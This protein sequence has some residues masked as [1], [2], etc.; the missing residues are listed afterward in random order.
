[1]SR[2]LAP[3]YLSAGDNDEIRNFKS[4][5]SA[6]LIASDPKPDIANRSS[7][8]AATDQINSYVLNYT[9]SHGLSYAVIRPLS[10][11]ADLDWSGTGYGVSTQCAAVPRSD[12]QILVDPGTSYFNCTTQTPRGNILG[13]LTSLPHKTWT[14]DWHAYLT[15]NR[16]LT[17]AP[18]TLVSKDGYNVSSSRN[19]ISQDPNTTFRNPWHWMAKINVLVEDPELPESFLT[20]PHLL[21]KR[22]DGNKS[23]FLLNCNT[24]GEC[25]FAVRIPTVRADFVVYD[26][27]HTVVNNMITSLST[28]KSNGSVAGMVS[29]TSLASL[30]FRTLGNNFVVFEVNRNL[31]TP[32]AFIETYA[33]SMSKRM[34]VPLVVHTVPA[35]AILVQRRVTSVVTKLPKLALWLLVVANLFFA[36]LGLVLAILAL[37]VTSPK[38]HQ[39]Q[40]RLSTAGLVA[41]LFDPGHAQSEAKND[42]KLFERDIRGKTVVNEVVVGVQCTASGGAEFVTEE[43]FGKEVLGHDEETLALQDEDTV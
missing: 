22:N 38:V 8:V 40:I 20:S 21:K 39:V 36:L 10:I 15:E 26:T 18:T 11:D 35:P 9:D 34:S 43:F 1:M 13:G 17:D 24:T 14:D 4:F 37:K 6:A 42:E 7:Y 16:S 31:T 27:E 12:C 19:W 25:T 41:Q 3:W 33:L 28:T 5:W 2:R 23:A 29:M 32:E 30:N